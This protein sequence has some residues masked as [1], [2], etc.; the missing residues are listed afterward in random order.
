MVLG[1]REGHRVGTGAARPLPINAATGYE[2]HE[3]LAWEA[4]LLDHQRYEE[5]TELL[6][7]DLHYRAPAELFAQL[8]DDPGCKPA[9][10][11]PVRD[12]R[13]ILTRVREL[14][15]RLAAATT[16][17]LMNVHRLI[18]NVMVSPAD[19][20]REFAVTSYVLVT[21]TREGEPEERILTVERRDCLRRM[22]DTFQISRRELR[23]ARIPAELRHGVRFL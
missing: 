4:F 6:S 2:I 1:L 23:L 10:L 21:A 3:F 18:T 7:K 19:C 5:W 12:H 14:E 17:P 16:A 22:S 8:P 11:R 9:D 13:F 15:G 20:S